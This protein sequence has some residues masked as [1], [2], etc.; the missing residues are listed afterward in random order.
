MHIP[1]SRSVYFPARW[2]GWIRLACSIF[3]FGRM[4]TMVWAQDTPPPQP[5]GGVQVKAVSAYFDYYS[6]GL[7]NTGLQS[8]S[9]LLPDADGGASVQVGWIKPGWRSTSTLSYTSTINARVR[10]SDWNAWNNALSFTTN[11]KLR[12]RLTFTFAARGD[13]STLEQSLFTPTTLSNASSVPATFDDFASALLS[14][15]FTNVQLESVLAAA[16]LAESPVRN[17]VYGDR[18]LTSGVQASF[19]YSYSPRLSLTFQAGGNR[20]QPISTNQRLASRPLLPNTTSGNANIAISYSLSPRTQIG[21]SVATTRIS[22]AFQ[23]AY[24][25]T[26]LLTFGRTLGRR[27]LVQ[28]HGGAG[29]TNL[30]RQLPGSQPSKL[31][32]SA[33]GSWAFKMFSQTLLGS[34]ERTVTDQYGLGASTSSSAGASW[35]WA[36]PGRPWWLESSFTWQQLSGGGLSD[37]SGWRTT[38]GFGERIGRHFAIMTQYAYMRYSGVLQTSDYHLAQSAVRISVVWYPSGMAQ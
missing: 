11:Y 14:S 9:K 8:S 21:G 2:R 32:P 10:Y 26:S 18:V 23:D 31:R 24:T 25:T 15:R 28:M 22:S 1:I 13:L 20:M 34:L 5:R 29:Y 33:G 19:G 12:P 36:R 16:P 35:R 3:A 38:T 7:S 27:W 37:L 4:T 30:V 17:L 6:S